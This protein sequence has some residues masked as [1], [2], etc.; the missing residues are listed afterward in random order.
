MSSS[1][2]KKIT[3]YLVRTSQRHCYCPSA[4]PI[5]RPRSI[6]FNWSAGVCISRPTNAQSGFLLLHKELLL[7]EPSGENQL[8][9]I[10]PPIRP[11]HAC[12]VVIREAAGNDD[13][14]AE[15][16]WRRDAVDRDCGADD[17]CSGLFRG[18]YANLAAN[19]LPHL[20]AR[21]ALAISVA[22]AGFRTGS[23]PSLQ[24]LLGNLKNNCQSATLI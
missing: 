22:A 20:V 10:A 6:C 7:A 8:N 9:R 23:F 14:I 2:S 13:A 24:S 1:T 18:W 4:A 12:G 11:S 3:L 17:M 5:E 15:E 21:A 16:R 19:C